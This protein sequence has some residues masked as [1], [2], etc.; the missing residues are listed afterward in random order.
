MPL[1]N[2]KPVDIVDI[3]T[4]NIANIC[5]AFKKVN[6]S[7]NL[8]SKVSDFKG[9]KIIL[10]GVGAFPDF[11]DKLK[12]R[13]IEN[14][15]ID[16]SKE[17]I[18]IRIGGNYICKHKPWHHNYYLELLDDEYDYYLKNN[19]STNFW[20]D[21]SKEN[22]SILGICLGF[23]V[24]F[25]SSTEHKFTKGLN[26]LQGDFGLLESNLLIPH[27]GW[28]DCEIEKKNDLFKGINNNSDFYFTHSYILKKYKEKDIIAFTKYGTK[29][30]SAAKK[31]NIYGVQFHP[32]K[33]QDKGLLILKNFYEMC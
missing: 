8:C 25:S 12:K 16:K 7:Y 19:K 32:E 17:N 22:I 10:P 26:L 15:I 13:N 27:V 28:N 21:K 5:S 14:Y 29:F 9:G 24:L 30:P 23:Q 33:S 2:N 3:G 18:S 1:I 31:N 4:G 11:M 20:V 6:I